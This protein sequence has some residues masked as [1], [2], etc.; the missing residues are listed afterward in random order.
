ML[1]DTVVI[2]VCAGKGG[3]GAV[4]FNSVMMS[5]GPTGAAGGKGGDIYLVAVNDLGALR[6]FRTVKTFSAENGLNGRSQFRDGRAGSDTE[7][8]VPRGTAA[9]DRAT[10]AR[11]EL[12]KEGDRVCAAHGGRGGKGNFSFRS[13]TNTSPQEFEH[14]APGEEHIVELEL[15]LI[16]DIGLIGLPNVGKSSFLNAVTNAQSPV[17]NYPFTTLE[18]HLG[19]YYG[20]ILA[21][22][23]GLIEGASKGKGLGV[24]FLR[25]IERTRMLFHFIDA[26]AADPLYDYRLIRDELRAY[27]E[28]LLEKPE[29]IIISKTDM[30]SDA[31]AEEIKNAFAAREKEIIP[32]SIHSAERM[33]HMKKI[34][35]ALCKK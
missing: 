9:H 16:A 22:L 13:S 23:P 15:K 5:L 35:N 19:M 27:N 4:A 12:L 1:I 31:R 18:P 26:N 8:L 6:R 20:L 2:K 24:K 25:H 11:Y 3:D 21:D 29:Y 32:F 10:G 17:A 14:G 33:E 30:V 7:L 28:A 34:L